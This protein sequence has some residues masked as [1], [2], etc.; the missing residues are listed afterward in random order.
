MEQNALIILTR[1]K[2]GHVSDLRQLLQTAIEPKWDQATARQICAKEMPFHRLH[3]LHFGCFAILDEG[4]G[5]DPIAPCLL[6]EATVDGETSDFIDEF[7]ALC[8]P[9]LDLIYAHCDGY[10]ETGTG[11][12]GMVRTYLSDHAVRPDIHFR[13]HPGRTI[14]EIHGED[15][16]RRHL[17]DTL[18][19][20]GAQ[21]SDL[22]GSRHEMLRILRRHV[23][24]P[25]VP[26]A[27]STPAP[28]FRWVTERRGEPVETRLGRLLTV[29]LAAGLALLI[30]A[31]GTYLASPAPHALTDCLREARALATGCA[32]AFAPVRAGALI[33]FGLGLP[34]RLGGWLLAW[35]AVPGD[36][37]WATA[38]VIGGWVIGRGTQFLC[39]TIPKPGFAGVFWM[40]LQ[41]LRLAA[42]ML[43]FT[44]LVALT[45]LGLATLSSHS[46]PR[47]T[48][49]DYTGAIVVGVLVVVIGT[50]AIFLIRF[51]RTMPSLDSSFGHASPAKRATFSLASD[52]LWLVMV[53]LGWQVLAAANWVTGLLD[54][55]PGPVFSTLSAW[56]VT[57]AV[58]V[59]LCLFAILATGVIWLIAIYVQGKLY[60]DRHFADA[61]DLLTVPIDPRPFARENHGVNQLQNHLISLSRIK[62]G[63]LRLL[64]LR[65][66]LFIVNQMCRW[67]FTRGELGDVKN[68]HFLRWLIV[69]KGR[70]LLFLDTYHGSWSGYLDGFI[71]SGAVRMLNAIWSHTYQ[72]VKGIGKPV[73]FPRT[74]CLGWKG[75]RDERP[76]KE[77]VR[78]SQKETIV[79]YSAYP[80]IS[81][82]GIITNSKIRNSLFQPL[83][84]AK[85]D[86]LFSNIR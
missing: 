30:A 7:I 5:E 86:M 39:E 61:R 65:L 53:V 2:P 60:D 70:R 10:P 26:S 85:L 33:A 47:W 74:E 51:I 84:T 28:D 49:Q 46:I 50:I 57:G 43:R 59:L 8:G 34:F 68:I 52:A 20:H 24:A 13:G 73:G 37:L 12:P 17:I 15:A 77:A 19:R 78:A 75:A 63:R 66:V 29:L 31:I 56:T 67:W 48:T 44:A 76:F 18:D 21:A 11:L 4:A 79:W 14:A 82:A 80:M 81:G 32:E 35:G 22:P 40:L 6:F 83:N 9:G 3:I 64:R 27:S 1:I 54:D 55:P 38:M 36:L 23:A 45:G 42:M 71:D 16:L 41:A 58:S 69:D 25:P 72:H 62:P